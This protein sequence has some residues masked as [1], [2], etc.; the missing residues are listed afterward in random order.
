MR[1]LPWRAN[2]TK[3]LSS[4]VGEYAGRA[5]YL[6]AGYAWLNPT[7]SSAI[8]KIV[9]LQF[10]GVAPPEDPFGGQAL[11]RERRPGHVLGDWL[12]PEQ[13]LAFLN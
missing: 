1:V 11:Y 9:E 8:G 10:E 13:D 2:R 5:R 4:G 12:I 6:P 3:I 7:L